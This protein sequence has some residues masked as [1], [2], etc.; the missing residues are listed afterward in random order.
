MKH[1]VN[2]IVFVLGIAMQLAIYLNAGHIK[3]MVQNSCLRLIV[4]I[5]N[6]NVFRIYV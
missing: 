4:D 1:I 3:H 2:N 5:R 6:T